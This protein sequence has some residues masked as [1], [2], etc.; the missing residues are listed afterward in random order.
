MKAVQ[1]PRSIQN[2]L[3]GV[4]VVLL[5]I[6][7]FFYLRSQKAPEEIS[8]FPAEEIIVQEEGAVRRT[9]ELVEPMTD[10]E[11]SQMREEIEGVLSIEG[12]TTSL[13]DVSGRQVT[14]EAKRAF[15]E[16][17]FYYQVNASGLMPVEKGFYYQGWLEKDGDYLSTGRV[18]LDIYGSGVLYYTT[19][20][21]RSDYSTAV[22]TLEPEDG[23]P[24]PAI[25]IL[26]AE[27]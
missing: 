25:H 24:T 3:I 21:D 7:G 1:E 16:G 18:E 2:L 14:G 12:E 19:S 26:E 6:A 13:R 22:I 10:E 9:G 23:D 8:P 11:I 15:S 20:V 27:F 4:G 17:K 5:V